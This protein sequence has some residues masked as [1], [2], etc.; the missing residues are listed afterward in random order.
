M[1]TVLSF[2]NSSSSVWEGE[3][4]DR[5]DRCDNTTFRPSDQP[6]A[7]QLSLQSSLPG[8]NSSPH[9]RRV[10]LEPPSPSLLSGDSLWLIIGIVGNVQGSN[11]G[12]LSNDGFVLTVSSQHFLASL[13]SEQQSILK[14]SGCNSFRQTVAP[15]C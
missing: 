13:L 12:C 6:G 11:R 4:L 8:Y 14:H 15:K 10:W 3:R 7:L 9:S 5:T 2:W 1:G